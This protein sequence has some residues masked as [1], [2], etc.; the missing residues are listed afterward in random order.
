MGPM[1]IPVANNPSTSPADFSQRKQAAT[2]S[3]ATQFRAAEDWVQFFREV[4]GSGGIV[5]RLFPDPHERE[6]F[7]QTEEYRQIQ[8]ML[9]KLREQS[10][11]PKEPTKVIT[12]RMPVSLHA[13][14]RDEA[15]RHHGVSALLIEIQN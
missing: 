9:A 12:V 13:S 3:T 6:L 7:Q 8:Q 14:L 10:V 11:V 5:D 15:H 1:A 2:S 4:L